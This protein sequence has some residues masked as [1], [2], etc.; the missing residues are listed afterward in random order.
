MSP[1]PFSFLAFLVQSKDLAVAWSTQTPPEALAHV[2]KDTKTE[3]DRD[4]ERRGPG[5]LGGEA[6]KVPEGPEA[7]ETSLVN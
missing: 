4:G 6:G 5:D 1:P 2:N 3:H 7:V